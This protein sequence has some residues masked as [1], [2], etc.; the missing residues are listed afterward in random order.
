MSKRITPSRWGALALL[1]ALVLGL[2]TVMPLWASALL[3]GAA[4]GAL[5]AALVVLV[6]H[7]LFYSG[8]FEDPLAWGIPAVA[9]AF[10]AAATPAMEPRRRPLL[11]AQRR[12]RVP[13]AS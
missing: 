3:V 2:G 4:A 11:L 10:L 5:G 7:S 6:V 13:A 8:F 12:P 9:T 1:A